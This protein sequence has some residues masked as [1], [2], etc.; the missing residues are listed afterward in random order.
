MRF[1]LAELVRLTGATVVRWPHPARVR[2]VHSLRHA[3]PDALYFPFTRS[4]VDEKLFQSLVENGVAGV[5]LYAEQAPPLPEQ[6]PALG[7]LSLPSPPD[8]FFKLA[9]A[10]REKSGALVV[11]VTGSS[12]KTSTKEYLAALLR[13]RG[14]AHATISSFNLRSDCAAIL[15]GLEEDGQE[16]AVIE[17]GFGVAGDIDRMAAT[18]RPSAGII[19]K[20]APDHLDGAGGSWEAL[21]AEKGKLGHHIP[22]EGV[23]AVH[24][25]DPGCARLPR[26]EYRARVLTFGAGPDADVGYEDVRAGE[27]GTELVL[28]LFGERLPCRLQ[29]YGAFQA[30]NAAAAALVAHVAGGL[31]PAVIQR[32]LAQVPPLPRRFAIHRYERGLTIID[33]TWSASVDAMLRGLESAA[34]LADARRKVA[35]LSGIA[36]LD[37]HSERYHRAVGEHAVACGFAD[38]VLY[39]NGR[40][41]AIRAGLLAAGLDPGRIHHITTAA[42]IPAG[43]LPFAQPDTLIYCKASQ[44]LWIGPE[45]DDL[46]AAVAAAFTPLPGAEEG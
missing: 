15:M 17:M 22:P 21:I 40:T 30:A 32:R 24:A 16:A 1:E 35:L 33:D 29:A 18:A 23:L 3:A 34:H 27:A 39:G 37:A 36:G 41:Q 14:T 12:G 25:E 45:L 9:T 19:T 26:G 44:Y 4:S 42:E 11:G 38:V 20:V 28:R 2:P 5:V 7:A 6:F 46:R 10:A 13:S 8:G 31:A 43:L